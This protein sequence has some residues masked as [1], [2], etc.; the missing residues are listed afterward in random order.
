MGSQRRGVPTIPINNL[1]NWTPKQEEAFTAVFKHRFVLYGGARG[2]GKSRWL[3]W[4]ALAL[5]LFWAKR[6]RIHGIRFGLFCATYPEL[7]DRQISKIKEEFP[8]EVGEIKDTQADGLCF[9]IKEKYGGGKIALRNLDD[10]EKYRSAEFAG[11]AVDEL[12]LN[13]LKTFNYLRGSLRWS[14]LPRTVFIAATN[15]GGVG[16]LWVKDYWIDGIFPPEMQS[17]ASEFKFIQSLPADNKYLTKEYW[18]DLNSLPPQL[19]RAWVYGDWDLFEGQAFSSFRRDIHVIKPQEIP[20]HWI[21]LTGTDSGFAAPFC[22]LW[23]AKNP[24][25]GRIVIYREL[26]EAGLTDRRQA[27]MILDMTTPEE[28]I[29]MHYADPALWAKKNIEN[30]VT[31]TADEYAA[32]GLYLTKGD[33]DRLN[34]KRKVDR[35]LEPLQDGLPGLLIFENCTNLIRTLPALPYDK[36]RIEDVDTNAEDH[37][38]D[39]LKYLLTSHRDKRDQPQPQV[40]KTAIQR[41]SIL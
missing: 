31:T 22:N 13:E 30:K 38:Y 8:P 20:A 27:R 28:K 3:R 4:T 36:T 7:Q 12:T 29:R 25:N 40:H 2:G 32:E 34:G 6:Y 23:G 19:V 21:R 37:A 14:G 16:H 1:L 5:L 11:V 35:L 15:P 18:D 39:A 9:H 41:I 26:Y 10:P 17:L 24:D 33:N